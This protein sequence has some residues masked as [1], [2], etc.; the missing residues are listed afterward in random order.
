M[1]KP[2]LCRSRNKSTAASRMVLRVASVWRVV[3]TAVMSYLCL[4]CQNYDT[5]GWDVKTLDTDSYWLSWSSVLF[6]HGCD[7]VPRHRVGSRQR[8]LDSFSGIRALSR[9]LARRSS[10]GTPLSALVMSR[11]VV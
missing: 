4:Q 6:W 3:A 1:E 10:E 8:H 5:P 11:D 7:Y 9:H 2:S